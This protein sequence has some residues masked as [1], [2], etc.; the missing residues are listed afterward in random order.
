MNGKTQN[1]GGKM[2]DVRYM[3]LKHETGLNR[4]GMRIS[5]VNHTETPYF[6]NGDGFVMSRYKTL[7]AAL[8]QWKSDN[9]KESDGQWTSVIPNL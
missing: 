5:K 2:K 4:R 3:I 1:G 9:S 7:K 6:Y 8:K